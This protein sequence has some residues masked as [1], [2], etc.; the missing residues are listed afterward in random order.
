MFTGF[1]WG[2]FQYTDLNN[3]HVFGKLLSL[4]EACHETVDWC[5]SIGKL[6]KFSWSR[7]MGHRLF[8]AFSKT[9]LW[10]CGFMPFFK[11]L[12]YCRHPPQLHFTDTHSGQLT[13]TNLKDRGQFWH[14]QNFHPHLPIPWAN[15]LTTMFCLHWGISSLGIIPIFIS[16]AL[17]PNSTVAGQ[18]KRCVQ[19]RILAK[20]VIV[21]KMSSGWECSHNHS[22]FHLLHSRWY[23]HHYD[24]NIFNFITT[25]GFSFTLTYSITK[26]TRAPLSDQLQPL[27]PLIDARSH[28]LFVLKFWNSFKDKD[29]VFQLQQGQ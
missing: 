16:L 15:V 4:S 3:V 22:S 25:F 13:P 23:L 8:S 10:Q 20:F 21:R 6:T 26:Q 14:E 17:W 7:M 29:S 1:G 28:H 11:M 2:G 24:I 18:I 19:S 12:S 5:V 9:C 27:H